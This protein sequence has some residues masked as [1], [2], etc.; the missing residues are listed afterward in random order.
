I[1]L[2][3]AQGRR[4]V[5]YQYPTGS[6]KTVLFSYIAA[7]A[8]DKGTRTL[9]VVHRRELVRQTIKKLWENGVQAGVLASGFASA[10]EHRVQIAMIQGLASR[11]IPDP[12]LI[13]VDEAHHVM[14]ATYQAMKKRWPKAFELGVTATPCRQTGKGLGEH[15]DTL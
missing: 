5:L 6:G 15:Y 13:V 8:A 9:I 10:P 4:R 14:A 2:A 12:E 3:F 7:N 11:H 1:R